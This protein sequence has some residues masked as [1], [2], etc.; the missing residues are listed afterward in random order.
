MS[1]ATSE[2]GREQREPTA[3][4]LAD[5]ID[6][7]PEPYRSNTIEWLENW[8]NMDLSGLDR[9]HPL[10]IEGFPRGRMEAWVELAGDVV[11]EAV[12]HFGRE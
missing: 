4:H 10:L 5:R 6:R 7:L 8:T 9:D 1:D 3:E 2:R 11:E 12:R